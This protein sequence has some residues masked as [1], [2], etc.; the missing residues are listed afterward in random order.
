MDYLE[1]ALL[2]MVMFGLELSISKLATGRISAESI[3]LLRC[4]V[5]SL[6]IAAFMMTYKIPL[7]MS[8][9]SVYACV[10]GIVMGVGFILI[11][12]AFSK[13]PASVVAPIMGLSCVIPALF[14]MIILHE[15]ITISKLAGL[16]FACV[17]IVLISR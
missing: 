12:R 2:G 1:L 7:S 11:F 5:A 10:A 14:G 8:R 17:A 9:F 15:P 13:G 16:A 3:A 4:I 6:I